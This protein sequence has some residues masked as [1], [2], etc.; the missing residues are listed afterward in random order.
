[1]AATKSK[2]RILAL[3]GGPSVFSYVKILQELERSNPGFLSRIDMLAG[4]SNGGFAALWLA[5]HKDEWGPEDAE[6]T[7]KDLEKFLREVIRS[8]KPEILDWVR[9]F[10][11]VGPMTGLSKT[12]TKLETVFKG[13][14]LKKIGES[15]VRILVPAYALI[16]QKAPETRML[17]S[18]TSPNIGD[19][20]MDFLCDAE[21]WGENQNLELSEVALRTASFPILHPI[22]S[23][24]VDGGV[25][26]QNPSL[27]ALAYALKQK[28]I[29]GIEDVVI[30]S[31]GSDFRRLN[32]RLKRTLKR[33]TE[34]NGGN[35]ANLGWWFWLAQPYHIF[36]LLMMVI[37]DGATTATNEVAKELMGSRYQRVAVPDMYWQFWYY[38]TGRIE[39]LL[40]NAEEVV[41]RWSP[42]PTTPEWHL[43]KKGSAGDIFR[44]ILEYIFVGLEERGRMERDIEPSFESLDAWVK[45]NWMNERGPESRHSGAKKTRKR[46]IAPK[47]NRAVTRRK[48]GVPMSSI[49]K[50]RK[51]KLARTSDTTARRKPIAGVKANMIRK[52]ARKRIGTKATSMTEA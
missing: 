14:T 31:L 39:T 28:N 38:I 27:P 29:S 7:L 4:P 43:R 48:V 47:T 2:L 22:T 26:A 34:R 45:K 50:Q 32:T 16:Q 44:K 41:K 23:Y 49:T 24:S 3:D 46:S 11:G 20:G 25:G 19:S 21:P 36:L 40:M 17:T 8:T 12:K 9:L 10:S 13:Q 5:V 37:V 51:R 42:G 6:A 15:G 1:M 33:A 18:L 30:L 52:K 35:D